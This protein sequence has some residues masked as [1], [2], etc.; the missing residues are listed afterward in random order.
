M[1]FI[2]C[3]EGLPETGMRD[4]V[5]LR[6]HSQILGDQAH[7][8]PQLGKAKC[9][10]YFT[11]MYEPNPANS[12]DVMHKLCAL[13]TLYDGFDLS[14]PVGWDTI[15]LNRYRHIVFDSMTFNDNGTGT[16]PL[17]NYGIQSIEF[18]QLSLRALFKKMHR[19]NV[20][21]TLLTEHVPRAWAHAL[22]GEGVKDVNF[23]HSTRKVAA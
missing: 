13:N 5:V 1:R 4:H 20:S 21:L 22:R 7:V 15:D 14:N 6:C 19:R 10:G 17:D 18:T 3:V 2:K 23:N 11:P 16:Q 9:I 12:D 8:R